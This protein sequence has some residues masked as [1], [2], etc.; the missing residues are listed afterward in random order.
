MMMMNM[1]TRIAAASL[2]LLLPAMMLGPCQ[3]MAFGPERNPRKADFRRDRLQN[4][5]RTMFNDLDLSS[6]QLEKLKKH[7]LQ[8][9]KS[10]ITLRSQLDLLRADMAEA[11]FRDNPD[12]ASIKVIAGKIGDL[13]AQMTVKRI[14]A[15]IYLRSILN[16]EQKKVMDSHHMFSQMMTG[17]DRN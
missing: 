6:K 8:Q 12:K 7:K 11:A 14:E 5:G 13:H 2:V 15:L 3:A 4:D 9:R 10:M 17:P 1:K 16:D